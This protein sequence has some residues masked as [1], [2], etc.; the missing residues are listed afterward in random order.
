M[1]LCSPIF[2]F[3]AA[4]SFPLNKKSLFSRRSHEV[5]VISEEGTQMIAIDLGEN[6]L[7][8]LERHQ[9]NAPHSCRTG[10]CTECAALVTSGLE[11]I[12]FG[13]AVLDPT[14]TEKGFILTCSVSVNGP[15]VK[16]ELNKHEEMYDAQYGTFRDDHNQ[17]Q[18]GSKFGGIPLPDVS[19]A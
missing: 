9:I 10:L 19:G 4:N 6:L 3:Q 5:E 1:M 2:A 18:Q 11:N 17:A 16:L 15:G 12:E 14:V 7:D 13:P 8:A